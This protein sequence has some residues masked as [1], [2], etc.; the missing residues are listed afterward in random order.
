MSQC[1]YLGP[2]LL[3]FF[4]RVGWGLAQWGTQTK[5]WTKRSCCSHLAAKGGAAVKQERATVAES[6]ARN[7]DDV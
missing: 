5:P 7:W 6:R 2:S 1:G 3:I 4:D